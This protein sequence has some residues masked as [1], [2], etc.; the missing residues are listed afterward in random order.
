MKNIN[1][2]N[3]EDD[4]ILVG[5]IFIFSTEEIRIKEFKS[6][7]DADLTGIKGSYIIT[8]KDEYIELRNREND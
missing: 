6:L 4:I 8:D 2:L 1:F 3:D 5:D 7:R